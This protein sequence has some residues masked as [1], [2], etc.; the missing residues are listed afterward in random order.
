M[1]E[2]TFPAE[3]KVLVYDCNTEHEASIKQFCK[4]NNLVA[5]KPAGVGILDVLR[6]YVD[7][8]AVFL[9]EDLENDVGGG[10]KLGHEIHRI[11][12]ELPI[13]LRSCAVERDANTDQVLR[14]TF[15]SI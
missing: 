1:N 7:L 9:S 14:K 11:R 2:N 8:G 12:P 6:S 13:I 4:K 15:C 10:I 5:V 3:S